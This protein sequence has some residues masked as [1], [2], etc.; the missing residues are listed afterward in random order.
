MGRLKGIKL[1]AEQK[2][3]MQEKRKSKINKIE[4]T[5]KSDDT[6]KV[7]IGKT[8]W[9]IENKKIIAIFPSEVKTYKGVIYEDI[10]DAL[11]ARDKI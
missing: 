8:K 1:T 6:K 10:N 3:K 5:I 11:K 2:N 9:A 7:K 4:K